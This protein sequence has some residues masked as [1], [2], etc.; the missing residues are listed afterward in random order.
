MI[1]VTMTPCMSDRCV[2]HF[3][4]YMAMIAT[5][6]MNAINTHTSISSLFILTLY[7]RNLV[8]S[9]GLEC[10]VSVSDTPNAAIKFLTHD[11]YCT[12]TMQ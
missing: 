4:C 8:M 3:M 2:N 9:T 5:M 1:R 11:A 6:I 7:M 10:H 12:N